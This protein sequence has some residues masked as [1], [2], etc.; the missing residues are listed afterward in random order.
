M[1]SLE[2]RIRQ[3]MENSE[4][5]VT[6]EELAEGGNPLA[7]ALEIAA[8]GLEHAADAAGSDSDGDDDED[9]E[10][11]DDDQDENQDPNQNGDGNNDGDK[12]TMTSQDKA[13]VNEGTDPFGSLDANGG[14]EA[15]AT[16]NGKLK[17]GLSKKDA[18][19]GKLES[20]PSSGDAVS[21]SDNGDNAK[22]KVGLSKKE[23]SGKVS[24]GATGQG[25]DEPTNSANNAG[26]ELQKGSKKGNVAEHMTA[27]FAGESLSEE[28]QTKA[29]TIFEAAVQSVAADRIA[30]LEEEYQQRLNEDA[31]TLMARMDEA[32]EET[33]AELVEQIDGY[34]NHVVESWINDNAVALEGAMKVELVNSFIDGMKGLFKEHYFDIPEDRLDIVEEQAK[35]IAQLQEALNTLTEEHDELVGEKVALIKSAIQEEI[36]NDLT[37]TE[38]E[39]FAGLVENVEFTDSDE[40]QQKLETIKESYFPTK[41]N[42]ESVIPTNDTPAV[43]TEEQQKSVDAYVAQIA[44]GLRF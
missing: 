12:P 14:E 16:K 19:P 34:L 44:K 4:S 43:M 2:E 27:L 11:D 28:F 38:K 30:A 40:Y 35:E 18:A 24:D 31:E 13:K 5:A 20:P 8:K 26:T 22:L 6:E 3:L 21:G 42:G 1:P 17:S 7:N 32:V 10:D 39:K 25:G 33:K 41:S 9:E 15:A 23:T 36:A 29:A 37:E